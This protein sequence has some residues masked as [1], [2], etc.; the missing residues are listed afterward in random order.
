ME[1][2]EASLTAVLEKLRTEQ[3]SR[4]DLIKLTPTKLIMIQYPDETAEQFERRCIVAKN[5]TMGE[6]RMITAALA[7]IG[8]NP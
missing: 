8:E 7:T 3:L 4:T 6:L 1:L 5:M 2:T